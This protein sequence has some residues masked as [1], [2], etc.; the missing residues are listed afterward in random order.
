MEN[1]YNSQLV[2]RK[3]ID[4]R[5][6]DECQCSENV[7]QQCK[8][9]AWRS[10]LMDIVSWWK[11]S[12]TTTNEEVDANALGVKTKGKGHLTQKINAQIKLPAFAVKSW[13]QLW[14]HQECWELL[15]LFSLMQPVLYRFRVF[16]A[17]E[18]LQCSQ[19]W[20]KFK[21]TFN[22]QRLNYASQLLS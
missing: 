20:M 19:T 12:V 8:S 21:N 22:P 16:S 17:R 13:H 11:R 6:S 7:L 10:L 18:L 1:N 14:I 5:H 15:F 2:K 9:N 4:C 3:K